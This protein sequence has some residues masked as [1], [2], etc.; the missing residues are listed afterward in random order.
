[1]KIVDKESTEEWA[2][3]LALKIL[4]SMCKI[5]GFLPSI[6]EIG[7]NQVQDHL[8][9]KMPWMNLEPTFV[10]LFVKNLGKVEY[11]YIKYGYKLI[12]LNLSIKI[13]IKIIAVVCSWS[14]HLPEYKEHYERHFYPIHTIR[15]SLEVNAVC[16]S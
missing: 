13:S 5:L 11:F 10:P 2:C 4:L 14:K 7:V 1:M 15:D 8:V 16:K 3:G 9:L 6:T 12:F